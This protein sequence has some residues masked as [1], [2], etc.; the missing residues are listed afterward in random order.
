VTPSPDGALLAFT[1]DGTL[2]DWAGVFDF[3]N[4]KIKQVTLNFEKEALAPLWSPDGRFLA[5]EEKGNHEKR[6]LQVAAVGG[7]KAC[8]LDGRQARNKF[9]GFS[10]P[11]WDATGDKIYFI[12]EYNNTFRQSLGLKPKKFPSRIGEA[13]P[14]CGKPNFYAVSEFME[15][16]PEEA[17]S[18]GVTALDLNR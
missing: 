1:V 2:H 7:G 3:S 6:S 14:H 9:M 17:R 5:V 16:F 11:W 4:K 8:I 13:S 18:H 12:T 15:K 10:K